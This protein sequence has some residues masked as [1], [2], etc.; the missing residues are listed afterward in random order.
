MI[1]LENAI[2]VAATL[3]NVGFRLC[4]YPLRNAAC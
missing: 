2:T 1:K 4:V 3:L